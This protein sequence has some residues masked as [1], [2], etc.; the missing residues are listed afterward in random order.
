ML[1]YSFFRFNRS[2]FC[3]ERIGKF[4]EM[5]LQARFD[6]TRR[7][8]APRRVASREPVGQRFCVHLQLT[9]LSADCATESPRARARALRCFLPRLPVAR[10][11]FPTPRS[12]LLFLDVP[13]RESWFLLC[14]LVVFVFFLLV[15]F[16]I[17][18]VDNLF[19]LESHVSFR[20]V[21]YLFTETR[22]KLMN[23]SSLELLF[24]VVVRN[25]FLNR[26]LEVS[27]LSRILWGF[28]LSV[29]LS[30]SSLPP[31]AFSLHRNQ[32]VAT[33]LRR[34]QWHPPI[35]SSFV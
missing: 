17:F 25:I 26:D 23:N 16:A 27:D 9:G 24:F 18:L 28:S 15:P 30:S 20:P 34:G 5:P 13:F 1:A 14:L 29:S 3:E 12:F 6:R 19:R 11:S 10:V 8:D 21:C 33:T 2:G 7:R 31:D 35:R 32:C 22:W 4:R